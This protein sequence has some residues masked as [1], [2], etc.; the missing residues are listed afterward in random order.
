[1]GWNTREEERLA[2]QQQIVADVAPHEVWSVWHSEY[3]RGTGE[4]VSRSVYFHRPTV[5]P[6]GDRPASADVGAIG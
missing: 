6:S 4:L 2:G 3:I 5:G 1:M